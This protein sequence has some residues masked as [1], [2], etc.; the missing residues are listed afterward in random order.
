MKEQ[1]WTRD[2][3]SEPQLYEEC[4]TFFL[5]AISCE[6]RATHVAQKLSTHGTV[7]SVLAWEAH[8]CR[9]ILGVDHRG[10]IGALDVDKAQ[11]RSFRGDRVH[12]R[13]V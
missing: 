10:E 9:R 3:L 13:L 2:A 8:K 12:V 4:A 6:S 11:L 1:I 7:I 5:P